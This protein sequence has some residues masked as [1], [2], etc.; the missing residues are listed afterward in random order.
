MLY[1]IMF[2]V[3]HVQ[4]FHTAAMLGRASQLPDRMCP[5]SLNRVKKVQTLYIDTVSFSIE[6]RSTNQIDIFPSII[7]G[8]CKYR[9]SLN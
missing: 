3:I 2:Y 1:V 9:L 6:L 4:T 8:A 5:L 7:V